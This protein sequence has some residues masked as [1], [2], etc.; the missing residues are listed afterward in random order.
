MEICAVKSNYRMNGDYSRILMNFLSI[1]EKDRIGRYVRW[2]DAQRGLIGRIGIRS[3]I[4]NRYKIKPEDIYLQTNKFG[5]PYFK[6]AKDVHFNI[7]HSGEWV[8]YA[9][10]ST[11]IGIDVEEIVDIDLNIAE[12]FFSIEEHMDL[13]ELDKS[14]R[15]AYFFDLWS[16]KESYIKAEGKGLSIPLDSF[17]IRKRD[18]IINIKGTDK[19][20]YFEQY[21][22][23]SN[24]K[25]SVCAMN[26]NFPMDINI[27]ELEEFI[28]FSINSLGGNYHE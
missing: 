8:V 1:E 23:L 18:N 20:Y 27:I 3:L 22:N 5:K 19:S 25:L 17:S 24:Y 7:S 6:A 10:D 14:D 9:M 13:M 15:L 12:R 2:E 21:D 4:C 28:Q 11:P 16:L 26:R